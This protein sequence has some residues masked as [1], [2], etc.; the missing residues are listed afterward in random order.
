ME[1]VVCGKNVEVRSHTF[2]CNLPIFVRKF[3]FSPVSKVKS[4]KILKKLLIA[5]ENTLHNW[6]DRVHLGIRTW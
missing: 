5:E 1:M 2:E 6:G 4:G 3:G